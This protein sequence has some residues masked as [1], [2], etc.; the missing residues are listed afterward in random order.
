[1]KTRSLPALLP[2]KGKVTEQTTVK[3]SIVL[4]TR[5]QECLN[6]VNKLN[7]KT[8]LHNTNSMDT[9]LGFIVVC[10]SIQLKYFTP[11]ATSVS[12][13]FLQLHSTSSSMECFGCCFL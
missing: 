12:S 1:M 2:F 7:N 5:F 8:S 10:T 13:S 6:V 4:Q 11:A 9:V 3:W